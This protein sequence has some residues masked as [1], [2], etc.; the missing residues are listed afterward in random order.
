MMNMSFSTRLDLMLPCTGSNQ[1]RER[2][3]APDDDPNEDE[4]VPPFDERHFAP[5]DLNTRPVAVM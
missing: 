2:V 4:T 1:T 5:P 3:K